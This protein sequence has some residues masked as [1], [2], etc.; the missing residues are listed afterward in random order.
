MPMPDFRAFLR[1]RF[2][3]PFSLILG[4]PLGYG[5]AP[6]RRATMA[7]A[8][9]A[10]R[11]RQATGSKRVALYLRVSTGG[12]TTANQRRE[13]EAVAKRH[14]WKVE[15]VFSD[16]G[17]SGAKDRNDRPGLD[18]LL[19]VVARRE[20]DMVAAWSVDRLGRSLKD[21][22]EVLTDL[23]AKGV[24]LYLH[25]QG[26]DTSTPSGRAMFQ[27]MGVF[28]E[29]ERA[30]IRERVLSGIARARAEGIALGRPTLVDSDTAKFA[31]IKAA[32]V[33]KRVFAA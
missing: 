25:Q 22:I 6:D 31:A 32:L 13:L 9:R 26:L 5:P 14:G 30:I 10:R 33:E 3:V 17:I 4:T 19:K 12:Q 2:D 27:M 7:T 11:Q 29:F 8:Q 24:D 20:V 23:H 21:L 28:A 16:N 1:P 15:Y 18:A